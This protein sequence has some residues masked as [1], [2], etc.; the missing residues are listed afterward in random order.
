MLHLSSSSSS[1]SSFSASGSVVPHQLQMLLAKCRKTSLQFRYFSDI[2][3][4]N[5][6][7]ISQPL[8]SGQ[9]Y[10]PFSQMLDLGYS[11]L[12]HSGHGY[13]DLSYPDLGHSDTSWLARHPD[14]DM[15]MWVLYI[16]TKSHIIDTFPIL[17]GWCNSLNRYM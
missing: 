10:R 6:Y 8:S 7:K 16:L 15:N 14:H 13:S 12:G 9:P 5:L 2:Y 1:W 17:S 11:D 4:A 3:F